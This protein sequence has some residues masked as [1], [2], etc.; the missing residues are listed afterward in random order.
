MEKFHLLL[1]LIIASNEA[2]GQRK[3]QIPNCQTT[4]DLETDAICSSFPQKGLSLNVKSMK[5]SQYL[6]KYILFTHK[7]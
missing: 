7:Q 3:V 1:L 2:S 6:I 5:V 4:E